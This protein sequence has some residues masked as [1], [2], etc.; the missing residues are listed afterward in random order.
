MQAHNL[1]DDGPVET[2]LMAAGDVNQTTF[3]TH[4]VDTRFAEMNLGSD[5]IEE[6]KQLA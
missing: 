3:N 1:L 6:A 4:T 2:P 5:L